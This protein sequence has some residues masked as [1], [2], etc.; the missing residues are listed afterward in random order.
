[1]FN[2]I[3]LQR[4]LLCLIYSGLFCLVTVGQAWAA[5]GSE[6]TKES[7]L[8]QK[9]ARYQTLAENV[10]VSN[11]Y[12]KMVVYP[13]GGFTGTTAAGE[14]WWIFY[15]SDTSDLTIKVGSAA[16]DLGGLA[17]YRTKDSYVN[18]NNNQEAIT[19][20]ELPEGIQAEQH[21]KLEGE[22]VTFTVRL[23]NKSN[24]PQ[25]VSLRYLWDTQL[26]DNDGSPLKAKGTLYTKE[27]AFSPVDFTN[28]TAYSRPDES[29]A[30][31]VTYGYWADI[32]DKIIFAHWPVAVGTDYSYN[33]DPNRQ[34][35]TSGYLRS[36][37]SDSCVL[38]YW[39]NMVLAPGAE[40]S[41]TAFYGT[42][43]QVGLQLLLR[44]D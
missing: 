11:D 17:P 28:W 10:S 22:K 36:P 13:D 3:Y 37:K 9:G 40:K 27:K 5:N 39:E 41:I 43:M 7:I 42:S 14:D 29:E 18:P 30:R 44:L 25:S 15:P 31:L 21:I 8:S 16:Y 20:W 12:L 19:E 6:V 35:Y 34:F 26:C 24:T 33:W 1:M 2:R 32:P 4:L 23:Q 38:M